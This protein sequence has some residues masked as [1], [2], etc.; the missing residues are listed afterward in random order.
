MQQPF[1][2]T[3][4]NKL[5]NEVVEYNRGLHIHVPYGSV[6]NW[7]RYIDLR[8][9]AKLRLYNYIHGIKPYNPFE[10]TEIGKTI[11]ILNF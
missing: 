9:K 8:Y 6:D 3:A 10:G 11:P 5:T 2:F 4:I 7:Q 1:E